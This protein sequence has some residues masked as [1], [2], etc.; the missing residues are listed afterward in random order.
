MSDVHATTLTHCANC[1]QRLNPWDRFCSQCGQDTQ[2]HAPS[3]WEF[4]H[5]WALHYVAAEGKL[6]KSLWALI[7]KPGF[8]TREYLAG[9]KQRY[10]LPLR[11]L[12]TFGLLFFFSLKLVPSVMDD[13]I[14]TQAQASDETPEA[15]AEAASQAREGLA[16]AGLPP[17]AAS[18]ISGALAEVAKNPASHPTAPV[19]MD[20][21]DREK[22]PL[23]LKKPL[24]RMEKRFAENREAAWV[25]FKST[26]LS[27]AP[28]AVLL[29]L[30]LFAALLKLLFPGTVYGAHFVFAM[31]LHAAWYLMLLLGVLLQSLGWTGFL[32][33]LWG[34]LYPLLALKRVNGSRWPSTLL[35]GAVLAVLH[36][37]VIVLVV[38][39]L[40]VIGL[41]SV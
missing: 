29:S 35:R 8:L 39:A 15:V 2:D 33:W 4:V 27:L 22:L 10:V 30:P 3:F 12:L 11:L 7:A 24:E 36:W 26:L 6:W 25:H 38:L 40:G 14:Q 18:A 17:K 34:N 31:H 37:G 1:G 16:Q 19:V 28:Y 23:W 9:R 21:G 41:V 5:E 20:A 32:L 13:V